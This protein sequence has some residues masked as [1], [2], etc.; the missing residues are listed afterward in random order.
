MAKLSGIIVGMILVSMFAGIF[1]IGLVDY[2]N[3]YEDSFNTSELEK[4]EKLGELSD[5]VE[6]LK[7]QVT[8][9]EEKSGVLDIVG[10]YFS[11]GY[12]GLKLSFK[13]V[14][15]FSELATNSVAD[16]RLGSSADIVRVSLISIVIVLMIFA[17]LSA[18]LRVGGAL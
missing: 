7:D 17:L 14:D 4:Y 10:G 18:I 8:S 16:A 12:Q 6:D 9:I 15:T 1:T 2:N 13:S 5:Q 11:S 3:K